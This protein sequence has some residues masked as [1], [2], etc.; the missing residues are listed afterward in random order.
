M[1]DKKNPLPDISGVFNID[2]SKIPK[3]IIDKPKETGSAKKT[4]GILLPDEKPAETK[5]REKQQRAEVKTKKKEA[6]RKAMRLSLIH[7]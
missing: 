7:I 4:G 1:A 3:T 2:E 6:K 5:K